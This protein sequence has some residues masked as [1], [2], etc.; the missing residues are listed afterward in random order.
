MLLQFQG[1][2]PEM[3]LIGLKSGGLRGVAKMAE[4][5]DPEFI[6]SHGKTKTI[7][8]RAAIDENYP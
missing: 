3:G 4:K 2:K 5:N 6:S 1:Q 8:H 7:I